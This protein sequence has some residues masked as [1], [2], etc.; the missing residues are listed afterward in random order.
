M[1][2][3]ARFDRNEPLSAQLATLKPDVVV[4][5]SGPFQ[6]YALETYKLVQACIASRINYLDL[7]DGSRFVAG[8]AEFDETAREAGVFV[9]SGVSSFPVL[10]AAIVRRLHADL[11]Q[12][13]T[14]RAVIAPSPFAGVGENVIRAIASYAGQPVAFLGRTAK[15]IGRPFTQH[16]RYTVAPPG[17]APL[18]S[19][20]FS[21]VDVPDLR[22]L[23]D[24]W[25]DVRRVWVG[26]GP[27]PEILHRALIAGAWLV[28]V[29][30]VRSLSPLAPLMHWA[31]N[32]VRWG[33][34]RGGMAVWIEGTDADG[35][36]AKHSWH[37]IAEGDDGAFVPSMA[38]AA[39]IENWLAGRKPASG[40]RA[41]IAEVELCDYERLF[42]GRAIV[43]GVRS[44]PMRGPLYR[45][46]LGDAWSQLPRAVQQMHEL[47]DQLEA[48]G[49]ADVTRGR[50]PLARLAAW[51]MG[52]PEAGE[53]IPAEVTFAVKDGRE[54]WTRRFGG[55]SFSSEQFA[56]SGKS[57]ALLCERFGV[58]TFAMAMVV[59][60]SR[61]QL[62]L[63]RWTT[64]G[65]ALPLCLAPRS[66]A[67]EAAEGD[68]FR[69]HVEISHPWTGLIVC[70]RGLLSRQ[71]S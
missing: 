40:A 48:Q 62:V 32:H 3:A 64:F 12:I 38:V 52:F 14:I 2:V 69:F 24:A 54:V 15:V 34:H 67:Y 70:Y 59:S 31:I 11:P 39:I 66:E 61:L 56:G 18:R 46:L 28:Q 26:A 65:I 21:L 22:A 36:P 13:R 5:A 42:A 57:E 16:R 29:G 27:A 41:A 58:L 49:V 44:S 8:I 30:L 20:M 53:D 50:H 33:E 47:D 23:S 7:A 35:R 25:P 55:R 10:T 71:G 68:A 37:M 63:R 1:L 43:S 4:D 45:Q 9:L 17:A 19:T 6:A 51:M 60:G